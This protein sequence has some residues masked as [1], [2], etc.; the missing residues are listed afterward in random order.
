M[1]VI[2]SHYF[3]NNFSYLFILFIG[4]IS[5]VFIFIL[6]FFIS[7]PIRWSSCIFHCYIL[8]PSKYSYFTLSFSFRY[9]SFDSFLWSST[10]VYIP[11]RLN[12]SIICYFFYLDSAVFS[13]F[14]KN[15]YFAFEYQLVRIYP[16]SVF[17]IYALFGFSCLY[18]SLCKSFCAIFLSFPILHFQIIFASAIFFFWHSWNFHNVSFSFSIFISLE[19]FIIFLLC[20]SYVLHSYIF[21][22]SFQILSLL[23]SSHLRL[24]I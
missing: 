3:R 21:L 6:F 16:A 22:S 23:F 12:P 15:T 10:T 19:G 8:L 13:S 9:S 24:I 2:Y 17:F 11:L 20:S 18:S 1:T 5:A 14:K 7:F 4:N